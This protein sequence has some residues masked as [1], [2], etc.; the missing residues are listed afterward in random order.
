MNT[1]EAIM[2]RKSTR[3]YK[4]VQLAE[5][6]LNV[7]L[8]A[9]MAS[10]VALAKYDSLHITVVQDEALIERVFDEAQEM[11]YAALGVR[12]N[13]NYGAKTL[14]IISSLPAHREGMDYVNG[15]IVIE[16]MVLAAT[17]MGVDSVIMG[18]P[19]A[20]LATNTELKRKLDIPHDFKPVIGAV[21]GYAQGD[22]GPK[23]HTISVNRV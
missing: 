2:K 8:K 20:A 22:E 11:V 6:V 17:D 12:K 15:G 5:D 23:Q 1:I 19:V 4:P 14:I 9:G 18:A 3:E 21:F 10:P 13:M 7:I 16:N